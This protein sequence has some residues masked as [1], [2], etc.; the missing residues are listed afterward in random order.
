MEQIIYG[1]YLKIIFSF[2]EFSLNEACTNSADIFLKQA[3][4]NTC[5]SKGESKITVFVQKQEIP[6]SNRS[7]FQYL[8]LH[9]ETV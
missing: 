2:S 9:L 5:N 6:F 1:N 3:L 4:A 7:R 8:Y